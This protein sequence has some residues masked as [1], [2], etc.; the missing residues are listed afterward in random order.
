MVNFAQLKKN[1][2]ASAE[3]IVKKMTAVTSYK[4][5]RYWELKKNKDGNGSA[6]IR[7][8]PA[9][10][11]DN[12]TEAY[13]STLKYQFR[14]PT[15]GTAGQWYIERS[16]KA[17]GRNEPDPVAEYVADCFKRGDKEEAKKIG[18]VSPRNIC[19]IY[20]EKHPAAPE[21]EGKVFLYEYGP[22]IAEMHETAL[23]PEFEG[24]KSFN[25]FDLWEGA[26]LDLRFKKKSKNEPG[27][28]DSSKWRE[29]GPLFVNDDGEA[30]D[31]RIEE[32]W[33][34]AY[35]L[36][37]ELAVTKYKPYDELLARLNIVLGRSAGTPAV[38]HNVAA[39]DDE[40]TSVAQLASSARKPKAKAVEAAADEVD[41]VADIDEDDSSFFSTLRDA[42]DEDVGLV[43]DDIPF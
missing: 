20:V 15:P 35:P 29:P 2:E 21:D 40:S 38:S 4:D 22:K 39:G 16:R 27:N 42:V 31:D 24:E 14:Y 19:G 28:Y 12:E 8:L 18:K 6:V 1:R 36:Q 43:D 25:P 41:D 23:L 17:L 10:P 13:V 11:G 33:S 3:A 30:D 26:T 5:P 34:R 37:P 9:P 32:V 7:F